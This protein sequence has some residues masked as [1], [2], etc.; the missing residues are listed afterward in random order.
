VLMANTTV[1]IISQTGFVPVRVSTLAQSA[2]I[3][4]GGVLFRGVLGV[5][6]PQGI[7]ITLDKGPFTR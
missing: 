4:P 3:D 2:S 5:I 7:Q 1:N 6:S